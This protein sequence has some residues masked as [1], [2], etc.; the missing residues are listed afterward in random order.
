MAQGRNIL[1]AIGG[2]PLIRFQRS[3]V[4]YRLRFT[5]PG[6]FAAR[7]QDSVRSALQDS[8]SSERIAADESGCELRP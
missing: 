3:A 1:R 4:R 5:E 7:Q 2:M 6:D 8:S